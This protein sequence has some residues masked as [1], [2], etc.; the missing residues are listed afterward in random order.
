M[1]DKLPDSLL[2]YTDGS[3]VPGQN[4][5]SGAGAVI[6]YQVS[7]YSEE[8]PEIEKLI[9]NGFSSRQDSYKM[10]VLAAKEVLEICKKKEKCLKYNRWQIC[11]DSQ[12]V[13]DHF[14]YC[15]GWARNGWKL[16][17]GTSPKELELWKSIHSTRNTLNKKGI[18]IDCLKVEGHSGD[19]YNEAADRLAKESAKVGSRGKTQRNGQFGRK[20]DLG[21]NKKPIEIGKK[22]T[23]Y[24]YEAMTRDSRVK[25]QILRPKQYLAAELGGR[26]SKC[27]SEQS[28]RRGHVYKGRILKHEMGYCFLENPEDLGRSSDLK[29]KFPELS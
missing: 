7:R 26:G 23:Y 8:E 22:Y 6:V 14:S 24:I 13:K 25:L 16:R 9:L 4:S 5:R 19:E 15:M 20:K 21:E 1:T 27:I 2:I 10:E 3:S 18:N 29:D 12:D 11:T 28:V 17:D